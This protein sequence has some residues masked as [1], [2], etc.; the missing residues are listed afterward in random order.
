[1][2][3]VV[4]IVRS[5]RLTRLDRQNALGRLDRNALGRR[6]GRLDRQNALGRRLGRLARQNALGRRLGR[7]DR[8]NALGRRLD[9]PNKFPQSVGNLLDRNRFAA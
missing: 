5:S 8:Q 1:M 2:V 3:Q 6:L 4:T 7:L 9:G